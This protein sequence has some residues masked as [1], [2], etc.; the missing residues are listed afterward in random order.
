MKKRTKLSAVVTLA[1]ISMPILAAAAPVGPISITDGSDT[2]LPSG[3][4]IIANTGAGIY[5]GGPDGGTLTGNNTT[6]NVSGTGRDDAGIY[7]ESARAGTGTTNACVVELGETVVYSKK[8]A[9]VVASGSSGEGNTA[10]VVLGAGSS[11]NSTE[12]STVNSSGNKALVQ[13]GDDSIIIGSSHGSTL[14][15][16]RAANAGRITVDDGVTVGNTNM[17]FDNSVAVMASNGRMGKG[18]IT[19]GNNSEIYS[20]STGDG[21]NAV[22][23]GYLSLGGSSSNPQKLEAS[24]DV[25]VGDSATIRTRGD[26][27]FA[28]H[29]IHADSTIYIGKNSNIRTEGNNSSAV[30]GGNI[31]DRYGFISSGG[32]I[33]VDEEAVINT[34]GASAH[35]VDARYDGS[36]IEIK[37]NASITTTGSAAH[38]VTA[39]NGG[40]VTLHDAVINVDSSKNSRAFSADGA[41]STTGAVSTITGS[42]VYNIV[43]DLQASNG[44]ILNLN[45]AE[46]SYLEGK[47]AVDSGKNSRTTLVLDKNSLWKVTGDSNLNSLHNNQSVIDMTGDGNTFS[48]L[49]LE[50]LSGT[51]GTIIMDIDGTQADV[52][53]KLYVTNDFSGAQTISLHE[54]NGLDADPALGQGA[55]NTVLA[56]VNGNGVLTADDREGTLYWERYELGQQAS[57]TAGYATDWYLKA[58]EKLNLPTTSIETIA[59][60]GALAYHTWRDNDLLMQR[61][62]DLRHSGDG[63]EGIWVRL[64]GGKLSRDDQFKFENKY[65]QY[66]LGY[67]KQ[68]KTTA[69]YDRYVGI[70]FSYLDGDSSYSSGSGENKVKSLNLY[71][72]QLGA[73]GHYL[74]LVV[75]YSQL[76][77]DFKVFDTASNKITGDYDQKG[78]SL[79]AEYGRKNRLQ[80]DWYIEPQAQLTLGRL[81]SVEYITSNGIKVAQDS[82]NSF[83]GRLGFNIGRDINAK[84]NIYLKANLMHEFGGGY[85][86]QMT[87][88]QGNTARLDK[89]FNDTWFEYGLGASIQT[90]KN[91]HIYLD[92]ERSAGS[93]YKKD[94]QWNVGAQ[95]TF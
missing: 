70:S 62:G 66:E 2:N 29:G 17:S 24:G 6:I 13:I 52:S 5:V 37:K 50:T 87:D 3:T 78:L 91:N 51:G 84:T 86:V 15:T 20:L 59:S 19:I 44:G 42:G 28:V 85:D 89:D 90:G 53:D 45:L 40:K 32:E 26:T 25:T 82:M 61:M 55:A 67:D 74:D 35:G 16:L 39:L 75:K 81:R 54:I 76:D 10:K 63:D 48:T 69:D 80:N 72:T 92:V 47:S 31:I 21:S 93:D 41:D 30:R 23:A 58:I 57:A 34:I 27:S 88:S 56:S 94:W 12:S 71:G 7:V 46:G 65:T 18:L 4:E 9:V 33:I 77:N 36:V 49:T 95:W 68:L 73:K 1:I 22:Q 64:K 38:G 43:G 83:V 11:L 14:A 8:Q 79:S 60:S